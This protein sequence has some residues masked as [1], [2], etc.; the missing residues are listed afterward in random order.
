MFNPVTGVIDN[1]MEIKMKNITYLILVLVLGNLSISVQAQQDMLHD[2]IQSYTDSL[3]ADPGNT[4]AMLQ[5]GIA[6][7]N[8]GGAGD[9]KAVKQGV[10]ILKQLLKIDPDNGEAHG[11][12]GSI[13]TMKGRDAWLPILSVWHVNEG[14]KAMDKAVEL[15]PHNVT[16]RMIRGNNNLNLPGFFDRIDLAVEDFEYL[17]MLNERMSGRLGDAFIGGVHLNLGRAY[18]QIGQIQKAVE[19][20]QKVIEISPGSEAADTA[21]NLM[22]QGEE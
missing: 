1:V 10:K 18:Q 17:V 11:W 16:V 6:Y 20:W 21:K 9:K 19:N 14:C 7:H 4:R 15:A 2:Q 3:N 22:N 12:Y 5:L 13:L 8:L